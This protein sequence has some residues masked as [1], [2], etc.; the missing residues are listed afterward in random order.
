MKQ[1]IKTITWKFKDTSESYPELKDKQVKVTSPSD[2]YEN[3]NFLF[4]GEV[5]ER[6]VVFG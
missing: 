5:K 2:I 4:A 6:F 1:C 3:F